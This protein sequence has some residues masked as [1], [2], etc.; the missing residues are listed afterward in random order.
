MTLEEHRQRHIE[1]HQKFDELLG[2]YFRQVKGA[3][4]DDSLISLMRW[5]HGQ[6]KEPTLPAGD[7]L[8]PQPR[9]HLPGEECT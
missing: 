4:T 9:P 1:L 7:Y 3:S 2:D 5:S 6:T 8:D